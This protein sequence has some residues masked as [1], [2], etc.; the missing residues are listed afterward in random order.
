MDALWYLF[1]HINQNNQISEW[2]LGLW[3]LTIDY[4]L[5]TFADCMVWVKNLVS[6]GMIAAAPSSKH[7]VLTIAWL[8]HEHVS[9]P[10]RF[11]HMP[12]CSMV[13]EYLPTF[14]P[15]WPSFVGK[16]SSTMDHLGCRFPEKCDFPRS[17]IHLVPPW[18]WNPQLIYASTCWHT[19]HETP[20]ALKFGH[21]CW[22]AGTFP[23]WIREPGGRSIV[24]LL[25]GEI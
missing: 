22:V 14:T 1:N 23:C 12:R 3:P 21:Y 2:I 25:P 16:Y 19:Q 6:S 5:G 24:S 20:G 7:R 9:T 10:I 13:L 4:C 8:R 18:L 11:V 15:K 17:I